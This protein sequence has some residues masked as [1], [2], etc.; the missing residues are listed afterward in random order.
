MSISTRHQLARVPFRCAVDR[1]AKLAPIC[2]P[3]PQHPSE[4]ASHER[5]TAASPEEARRHAG[6][7]AGAPVR[8]DP[9]PQHLHRPR[10]QAALPAGGGMVRPPA[11]GHRLRG[12]AGDDHRPSHGGGPRRGRPPPGAAARAVL[13]PLRRAAARPAGAVEIAA[14]R[15][16]HRLRQAQRQG[17]RGARR[18]GQQG[19]A[20][21]LLRGGT[22][23]EERG[24]RLPDRHHRSARGRGGMRLAVAARVPRRARQGGD[25]RPGAGVRHRPMGQGHPGHLHPAQGH[26]R[27]RDR[28]HRPEPGSAFGQLRRR[29]HEPHSRACEDHGRDARRR[30]QGAH[31]RILRR[32]QDAVARAARAMGRGSA[33]MPANSWP[34]WG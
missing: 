21:D 16:A 3:F 30:R 1:G 19:P 7:G 10:L 2:G 17:D 24:G 29:G 12:Q 4:Q 5:P 34:T 27:H 15:A 14:I 8:A 25:G 22:C 26:R 18:G 20:H 31:S 6:R 9:H 33:S 11:R 32:H 13:R 28:R 23:L